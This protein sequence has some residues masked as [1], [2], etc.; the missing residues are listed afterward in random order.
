MIYSI[1]MHTTVY[2]FWRFVY[3]H[4]QSVMDQYAHYCISILT[5]R[6]RSL[7][8]NIIIYAIILYEDQIARISFI[9]APEM[10]FGR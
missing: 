6:N 2:Q 9:M 1:N 8:T 3:H 10:E 5:V 4:E 7:C